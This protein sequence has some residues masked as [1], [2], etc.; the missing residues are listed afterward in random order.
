MSSTTSTATETRAEYAPGL[1][2]ASDE[3]RTHGTSADITDLEGRSEQAARQY[4]AE[5]S[6]AERMEVLFDFSPFDYQRDLIAHTDTQGIVRVAIQPGR[7]V[8]KTLTGAA[9]AA[10][11]AA[12]V[13]AEDTLIA[14]PFQETADE[15]TKS[16]GELLSLEEVERLAEDPPDESDLTKRERYIAAELETGA[17][18][19]GLADDL[20]ERESVVTQHLRDLY[21]SGWDVY[22][23][24]SAGLVTLEGD[25]A[26]RSSEHKG[27]RTRK[28]NQWWEKRHSALVRDFNALPTPSTDITKHRGQEDWVHHF[29][30]IHAGDKVLTPDRT[31]VYNADLVPEIVRYDTRKSLELY[32]YHGVDCDVAHLLWGGDF[33]TNEG[34]YQGQFEDLDAW[35]DEQH[36]MLMEPLLEQVKAYS[37]RFEAV[38]VVCQ[39]GNHGENRASGTSKQANAD[40]VL[41][42]SIRNAIAAV[43]KFGEG[44]AFGNVN[45]R[46]GQAR[47]Y[48]NFPLR[49]GKLRGHLR[50]GQDRKPQ[51][52]TRAGSDDWKTTLMN[53]DFDVSFLGHH[54][55]SGR[56]VWDGPPVIASGT[57][58][59]PSDFVD[60]I[61]AATSLDPRDQT[62]EISHCAGVA[63]H[64][65]TGVYPVKT[66]DFDYTQ[67]IES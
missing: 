16:L 20:D 5:L 67:S 56:I 15:D 4:L 60:R 32:D 36:D 53:H 65:V 62:R 49:G 51:A 7:Q 47:P 40:L 12:S 38:N 37:E 42:K 21:A 41:Y 46:I 6:R 66:H 26:L 8:G 63:D 13:A 33:V 10:D 25:H 14:A 3:E 28:A 27:T 57:P 2:L 43:I 34:I 39:V 61:A 22:I 35:L 23:D 48:T 24:D 52:T 31:N 11:D 44:S 54:H 30:D 50:H 59:P 29:S 64:G 9:L 1:E 17:T 55:S 18:V 45:F 58:K 19:D